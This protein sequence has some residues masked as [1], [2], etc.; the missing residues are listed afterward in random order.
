MV[1]SLSYLVLWIDIKFDLKK[2]TWSEQEEDFRV[3][4]LETQTHLLASQRL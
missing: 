1:E 2:N 3:I 4:E